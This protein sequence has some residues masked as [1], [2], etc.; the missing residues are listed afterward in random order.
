MGRPESKGGVLIVLQRPHS[1][2]EN[3]DGF[4]EGK[5]NCQTT[6][7]VSDLICAVNN[8]KL[9]FDDVSLFDAI[10]F[11]DETVTGQDHQDLIDE[12][13]NIFADMVRAK[14]P[15]IILCC[16]TTETR[17]SLVKKL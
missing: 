3:L 13:Q 7:A 2:Q 16:S 17:N 15:D 14:D 4:M 5:R 8:A 12:A 6:T 1:T 11:L 10:P 9:G